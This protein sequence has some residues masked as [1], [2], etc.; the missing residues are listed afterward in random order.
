MLTTGHAELTGRY[1]NKV[2]KVVKVPENE[3]RINLNM[4]E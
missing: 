2:V 1:I 4:L 3:N